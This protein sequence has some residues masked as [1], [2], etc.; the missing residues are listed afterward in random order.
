MIQ[1]IFSFF[2]GYLIGSFPTAYLLLRWKS[3]LDIRELGSGNVGAVNTFD[4]TGSK[5]L[6]VAVM[7]ID[8][9]KGV[10]AVGLGLIIWDNQFWLTGITGTASIVGHDFPIWTGFRGGRGLS[11]SAGVMFLI[12][13]VFVVGWCSIWGV[14]YVTVK[15]IHKSN[16][17]TSIITPIMLALIPGNMLSVLLPP[18]TGA[19]EFLYMSILICFLIILRH[20]QIMGVLLKFSH[21][22][23]QIKDHGK[24]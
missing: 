14:V 5:F 16:V 12:G 2:I 21:N 6:S 23:N 10:L 24:T 3:K 9:L 13:W 8:V 7:I 19:K 11:T 1:Y 22:A 4:V 15:D 17:I 20:H 18:H